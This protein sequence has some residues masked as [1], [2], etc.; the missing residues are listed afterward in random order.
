MGPDRGVARTG[1]AAR[2]A[3]WRATAGAAGRCGLMRRTR[4][5]FW[6]TGARSARARRSTGELGV[7]AGAGRGCTVGPAGPREGPGAARSAR[8]WVCTGRAWGHAG[9]GLRS[10]GKPGRSARGT[11]RGPLS[12]LPGGEGIAAQP[13]AQ[14][15]EEAVAC[16]EVGHGGLPTEASLAQG[17]GFLWKGLSQSRERAPSVCSGAELSALSFREKWESLVPEKVAFLRHGVGTVGVS[18]WVHNVGFANVRCSG[19]GVLGLPCGS[20]SESRILEPT[21]AHLGSQSRL[22]V[23]DAENQAAGEGCSVCPPW[24]GPGSGAP[25][26]A[27]RRTAWRHPPPLRPRKRPWEALGLSVWAPPPPARG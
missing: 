23:R 27:L 14:A 15:G 17:P 18:E 20:R 6:E 21:G 13:G 9:A 19:W 1:A 2:P 24:W 16:V 4:R 22:S 7:Y 3:G 10:A 5:R 8:A 11:A 26:S 12:A 25:R